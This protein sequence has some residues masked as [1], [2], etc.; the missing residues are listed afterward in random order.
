MSYKTDKKLILKQLKE[1]KARA[2]N[3]VR[4]HEDYRVLVN[5]IIKLT[6]LVF[7]LY[8]AEEEELELAERVDKFV[9]ELDKRHWDN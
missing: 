1:V 6:D 4:T 9:E 8:I 3:G 2:K 7:D 5:T